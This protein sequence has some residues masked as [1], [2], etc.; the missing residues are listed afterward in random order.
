MSLPWIVA[1]RQHQPRRVG[2]L[3]S[4][5]LE[6]PVRGG[7]TVDEARI[8]AELTADDVSAFV[9]GAQLAELI[10]AEQDGISLLEAF[11]IVEDTMSGKTLDDRANEIRIRYAERLEAVTHAYAA[12]GQRNIQASVTAI[13]RERLGMTDWVM[14][15]DFPRV[16]LD[17]IWALICDE[18]AAENLPAN[19]PTAADLG[20]PLPAAGSRKRRTGRSSSGASATDSPAPST[21]TPSGRSF[22][23]S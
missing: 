12:A 7:L 4:G 5:I 8:V 10:A 23:A 15:A 9:L 3:D 21:G 1:P 18:Q 16:L 20:K 19:R 22:A 2:T 13:M 14:P 17:D 6:I 11:A